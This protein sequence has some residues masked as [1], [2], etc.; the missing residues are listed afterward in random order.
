[1]TDPINNK[2]E[3]I[4]F[5]NQDRI[6]NYLDKQFDSIIHQIIPL[7]ESGMAKSVIERRLNQLLKQFRKNATAKI[8][9]GIKFSWDI[10]NQKNA[11]YIE[12]RL[13]R[14][15]LPDR[16]RKALL[17]PNHNRLE[18]F[19]KRK[20]G[21][22]NLS[23]RVWKTAGQFKNNID[24]SLDVGISQGNSAKQIGRE[25]RSNLQDPD[26]LFRRVRDSRG[27]LK[28]SKPAKAYNPG[29]GKYR[30]SSK[31]TE[32]LARTEI[33]MG[34]RAADDAAWENNPLVLGYE[35]RLSATAKPKTRCDLCKSLEGK[36]PVWFK[37]R[38][39]HPNCLCFKIPILM[40]DEM[41]A[42]YLKLIARGEDTP[43]ALKELQQDVRIENPPPDFNV[44]VSDN[45]ERVM[46][47]KQTPYW[48]KDNDKFITS[49][50]KKE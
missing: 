13:A 12:K 17:N 14:Y 9:S 7:I 20:E 42:K 49:V 44:W 32:R 39:W 10:S 28:L 24:M 21:G 6:V 19:I 27:N 34:Y 22:L 4:H 30:S 23:D 37:F 41:M 18:A 35:I 29:K 11:A 16:I 2:F 25:L 1:M 26:N 3:R 5:N 47:W 43:A 48:W 15:T 38:G 40:D 36:Y 8:E 50:L 45:N 31:N 46:G 33:N